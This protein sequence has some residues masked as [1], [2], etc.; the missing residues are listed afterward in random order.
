MSTTQ[1]YWGHVDEQGRVVLPPE[2]AAQYGL[3]PGAR[4]RV[5][6]QT[7]SLRMHRPIT[8][9]NRVYVEPTSRCNIVC[10]TC[11]RNT[12]EEEMGTMTRATFERVLDGL[13]EIGTRPTVMFAG[14]GEPL[15]HFYIA[16]MVRRVKEIGCRVEITTNGTMLN[17]KMSRAL[18]D[19]GLDALW[20]SLD[21]ASPESYEDVRLGA[22]LPNVIHNLARFREM[23][24]GFYHPKPEI[25]VAFV[26][27]KNNIADLP[28]V[29]E[30]GRSLGATL[31]SVSNVLPYTQEMRQEVLYER[32][33]KDVAYISSEWI[34]K[35]SLPK[36]DIN[37]DTRDAFFAAL[38]SGMSV[39]YAG[40]SF[41]GA[42][43]ACVFI[44]N[45]ATTIG[46]DGGVSPCPPLLH[47]HTV[48]TRNRERNLRR[49]ILGNINE[50]SLADLWNDEQYLAYR[51]R[52]H[53]FAFPPCSFCGGCDLLDSNQ[54]DCLGT[55]APVCGGCLWAQGVI[56]CP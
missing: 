28:R 11:M 46:W 37:D 39:T 38:K 35:L 53:R 47:N 32:T 40:N 1:T 27:M 19:A 12:W 36:M 30:L 22:E 26:A 54:E 14:I 25:G 23:R 6:P 15:G 2:F 18:I 9:L 42:N 17:E 13:R 31:F 55:P 44:E 45:G 29:L 48:F 24:K 41:S 20:V 10:R 43:D 49:H 3:T 33:L 50:R 7:N 51:E 21:G 8:H 52:V 4:F 56:Q 5:D 34:P 16:E